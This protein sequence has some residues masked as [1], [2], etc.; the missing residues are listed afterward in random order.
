[1]TIDPYLIAAGM[2]VL[3]V[4]YFLLGPVEEWL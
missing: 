2:L 3:A 1:M 4:A